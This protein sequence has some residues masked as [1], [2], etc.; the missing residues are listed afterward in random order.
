MLQ[1]RKIL[2]FTIANFDSVA[3]TDWVKTDACTGQD[4]Y[5]TGFLSVPDS[6]NV[7]SEP[8]VFRQFTG[9]CGLCAR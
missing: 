8:L 7:I 5:L 3:I 1:K 6:L 2:S 4:G 9:R